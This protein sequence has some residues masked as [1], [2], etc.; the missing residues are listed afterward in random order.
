MVATDSQLSHSHLLEGLL[1]TL[2][3]QPHSDTEYA[4]AA[5]GCQGSA[6]VNSH[7]VY[8]ERHACRRGTDHSLTKIQNEY[9]CLRPATAGSYHNSSLGS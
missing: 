8:S 7:T 3:S 4:R 2:T 6:N 5:Q 9:S 1:K